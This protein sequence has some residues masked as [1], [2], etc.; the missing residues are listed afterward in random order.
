GIL[1]VITKDAED[2]EGV[3]VGGGAGSGPGDRLMSRAYVMAG[4]SDLLHG[5]LK[6]F[7]HASVETYQGPA[8]DMPLLLFHDALPQPNSANVYGPL[9]TTNEAQSFI[10]NL[11]G[12]V[13]YD[14]LQ[15]RVSY[16]VG[17][18]FK[19]MGLS[20]DP[21]R[22]QPDPNDTTGAARK[23]RSDLFDR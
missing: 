13:T 15:L 19:P 12:K 8:F 7:G 2:V 1:N 10:V 23:N 9:T 14:K 18:M 17:Q 20:G 4:K 22:D 11:D 16:P 21:V 5:K 3:E 6:V